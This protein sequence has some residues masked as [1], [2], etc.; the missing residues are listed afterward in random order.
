METEIAS[1]ADCETEGIA[2][3]GEIMQ[4]ILENLESADLKNHL[5]L[6]KNHRDLLLDTPEVMRKLPLILQNQTWSEKLDFIENYGKFV[7]EVKFNDC[8]FNSILDPG[9]ILRKIPNVE[10]ITFVNCFV[11]SKSEEDEANNE[12]AQQDEGEAPEPEVPE[13]IPQDVEM[14]QN[15]ENVENEQNAQE[16]TPEPE[17][18]IDPLHLPRLKFLTLDSP[19]IG[20]SLVKY[21]KNSNQIDTL[22]LTYYFQDPTTIFNDFFIQQDKLKNFTLIG[23]SD[24]IFRSLF[25]EDISKMI[26]FKLK[27][28]YIECELNHHENFV[29]FLKSQNQIEDFHLAGYN[30]NYNYYRIIFH[31]LHN[32]KKLNIPIDWFMTDQRYEEIKNVVIPSVED[33]T[34]NGSNDDGLIFAGV[35]KMF[36]GLKKIKIE[37]L[38]YFSAKCLS[39]FENLEHIQVENYRAEC[40]MFA[41]MEKLKVLEVNYL[42]PFGLEA[43]WTKFA[44]NNPKVKKLIIREIGNF[45]LVESIKR[46]I[47]FIIKAATL[48]PEIEY[49]EVIHTPQSPI[50]N[51]DINER[52]PRQEMTP[53]FFKIILENSNKNPKVLKVSN[54]INLHCP[55][56]MEMLRTR[57]S[58]C[59]VVSL[60]S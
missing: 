54:Y 27:K 40:L 12:S 23:W 24:I 17:P 41:E 18:E 33:L 1:I 46:E 43:V 22:K 16:P 50:V 52:E 8:A 4:L 47:G 10:K 28:F 3:P 26:K 53:A 14:A 11:K 13:N 19:Q 9:D 60:N 49:F 58:D 21:F 44:A 45:K 35:T 57:F 32:I 25:V 59:A 42:Y 55:D 31:D 5:M 37:N 39:G 34:V 36:S 2:F 15:E 38:M 30:I 51:A 6:S 56:E 48:L 7:R 20:T 29:N